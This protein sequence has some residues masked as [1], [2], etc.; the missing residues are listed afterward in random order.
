[1]TVRLYYDS[2]ALEFDAAV[3]AHDGSDTR[4]ILDR[5]AFYPTSGGQPHDTGTLGGARVI[6]VIDD[7]DRIIHQLDRPLPPGPVRGSVDRGRRH[8]FT[9]QHTAQHLISALAADRLGWHTESVHFGDDHSTIEFDASDVTADHLARLEEW[10]NDAIAAAVPVTVWY[11]DAR[12]ASGLRKPS[13]RDGTIRIVSIEGIDRSACGGTHLG[14]TAAIGMIAFDGIERIR[15]RTR[16]SYLA[17]ERLLRSFRER[18]GSLGRTA[19]ILGCAVD[20]IAELLPRRLT[21]LREV[22]SRIREMTAELGR[23][24]LAAMM[25]GTAPDAD[26]IRRI[27]I[28]AGSG[29][30]DLVRATVQAA[31]AGPMVLCVAGLAEPPSILCGASADSGIHAGNLVREVLKE[32]GGRGGGSPTFAQ[33]SV[34]DPAL[35]PQ[36]VAATLRIGGRAVT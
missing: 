5:T 9:V 1:M 29:E 36:A 24:R 6:D 34:P 12:S 7:D 2:P 22:E 25:H 8:D 23:H 17:G 13:G 27:V 3:V 30:P 4:V 31:A 28:P 15:G 35:V 21:A 18:S 26:G 19:L 16:L 32:C 10:A 33:G 11:E 20:E 14:S